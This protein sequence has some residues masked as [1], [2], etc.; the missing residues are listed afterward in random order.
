[1]W[2]PLVAVLVLCGLAYVADSS[3]TAAGLLA[4]GVLFGAFAMGARDS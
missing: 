1:M 3:E 2:W 4:A